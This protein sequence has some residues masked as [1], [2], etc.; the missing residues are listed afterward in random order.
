VL[1]EVQDTGPGIAKEALP[2][3]FKKFYTIPDVNG[4]DQ[5]GSGLGLYTAKAL[6]ELNRGK[7]W[8]DSVEN[9]GS[10]FGFSLPKASNA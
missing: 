8:A 9:K 1:V 4:N 10:T 6:I 3:L 7:I 5:T 2:N